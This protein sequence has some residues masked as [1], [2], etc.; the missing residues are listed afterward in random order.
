LLALTAA[1]AEQPFASIVIGRTR[2]D[3][4]SDHATCTVARI[5]SLDQDAEARRKMALD[6]LAVIVDLYDRGMREPLP[7]AS[8]SSA[9]Y[10][11]AARRGADGDAAAKSNWET[12]FGFDKEDREP[13]HQ[14]VYGGV[15]S[16]A[17]LLRQRPRDDEQGRGWCESDAT[18]FGRLSRRLWDGLLGC[19]VLSDR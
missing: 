12:S 17:E 1:R 2:S 5:P 14:L 13:E 4:D 10:A 9:A 16:L 15:L 3:S 19:E 6:Q 18:R 11:S 7:I 8:V